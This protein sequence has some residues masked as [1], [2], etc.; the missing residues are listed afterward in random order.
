MFDYG[1]EGYRFNSYWVRHF[2]ASEYQALTL[3]TS[4]AYKSRKIVLGQFLANF[5]IV[6]PR[7]G[8]TRPIE[9][10]KKPRDLVV[11]S[12]T[13]GVAGFHHSSSGEFQFAESARAGGREASGAPFAE[14]VGGLFLRKPPARLHSL[15]RREFGIRELSSHS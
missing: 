6:D 1:S 14:R 7:R 2:K 10:E 3:L 13:K 4:A 9:A 8:L 11:Q 5:W 15:L 12:V